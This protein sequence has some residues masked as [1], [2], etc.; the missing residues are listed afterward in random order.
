[1]S[2]VKNEL[3]N[4]IKNNNEQFSLYHN[5]RGEFSVFMIM[6]NGL[7]ISPIYLLVITL[8]STLF[9]EAIFVIC[10]L[11][12]AAL[13]FPSLLKEKKMKDEYLNE[14][15][16]NTLKLKEKLDKDFIKEMNYLIVNK[17]SKENYLLFQEKLSKNE[18]VE[19][20][21]MIVLN[22]Y[23]QHIESSKFLKEKNKREMYL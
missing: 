7:I 1:M 17:K 21:I 15:K 14:K 13:V 18:D 2:Y 10:F 19:E 23:E 20:E 9:K 6:I 11:T 4:Y 22:N 12:I 16:K 8:L 5:K 3:E